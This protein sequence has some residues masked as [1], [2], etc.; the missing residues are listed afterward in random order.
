MRYTSHYRSLLL[1]SDNIINSQQEWDFLIG[2]D[3]M[4]RY[5]DFKKCWGLYYKT[6]YGSKC[7]HIVIS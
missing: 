1:G 4:L 3:E 6:F 7:F 5:W 2:L